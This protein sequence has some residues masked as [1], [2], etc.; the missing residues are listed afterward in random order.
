MLLI[1][2]KTYARSDYAGLDEIGKKELAEYR[3]RLAKSLGQ[4]RNFMNKRYNVGSQDWKDAYESALGMNKKLV[5]DYKRLNLNTTSSQSTPN[6]ISTPNIEPTTNINQPVSSPKPQVTTTP[7]E[8][9]SKP[10]PTPTTNFTPNPNPNPTPKP[11][12]S[13]PKP[14]SKPNPTPKPTTTGGK[15]NWKGGLGKTAL[16][17]AGIGLA[18]GGKQ[19]YDHYK[20]KKENGNIEK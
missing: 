20:N 4:K 14:I 3:G 12:T 10:T 11:T 2:E 9:V 16:I 1:R 8:S 13:T 15:F 19:A 6:T 17:G 18:I 5:K 7:L